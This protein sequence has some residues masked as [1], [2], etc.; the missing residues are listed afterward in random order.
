M[1]GAVRPATAHGTAAPLADRALAPASR[2]DAGETGEGGAAL[3]RTAAT[4]AALLRA[5]RDVGGGNAV[6]LRPLPASAEREG[7]GSTGR[8]RACAPAR[9]CCVLLFGVV[10]ATVDAGNGDR[11]GAGRAKVV[12]DV[13]GAWASTLSTAAG[14]TFCDVERSASRVGAAGGLVA[15]ATSATGPGP[16]AAARRCSVS[17]FGGAAGGASATF[18]SSRGAAAGVAAPVPASCT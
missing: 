18:A 9:G 6:A 14:S 17:A 4:V 12:S 7:T 5:T 13:V 3:G 16:G 10:A 2:R 15:G 1:R 11:P 8:L